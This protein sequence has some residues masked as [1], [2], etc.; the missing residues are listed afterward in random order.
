[1]RKRGWKVLACALLLALLFAGAD[2]A[3]TG[4]KEQTKGGDC[5]RIV[6]TY[7]YMNDEDM[8][9]MEE[10]VDA[11][12]EISRDEIGVEVELLPVDALDS[13]A[14]YP[15]WLGRGD[16]IDL[17]LINYQNI[18]YYVDRGMLLPLNGLLDC[19]GAGIEEL[20][21]SQQNLYSGATADGNVYGVN[22][23]SYGFASGGGLWMS[24]QLLEEASF[25][26]E[27]EH[28]YS[29]E[30]LDVL[31]A[32]LKER[33]PDCYP[34]GQITADMTF[35]SFAYYNGTSEALGGG[36]M[37]GVMGEDGALCDLYES[38]EYYEFL[39]CMRSWY[40]KGYIYPESAYTDVRMA[41]LLQEGIILS[42]P[43]SSQPGVVSKE[44]IPD[45][46]CLLTSA[47]TYG[48]GSRTGIFWTIP[49]TSREPEAA[50]EFLN[51]MYTDERIVNLF[52]LGI[53]GK[54]YV[55]TDEARGIVDYPK[56]TPQQE[57]Y[58]C[59]LGVYGNMTL[60]Y[61]FSW[62][63]FREERKE[64][65]SLARPLGTE[66]EGFYFD[67][68]EVAAQEARVQEVL[69]SYLPALESGSIPLAVNYEQFVS[70]L[71]EAGI[72][73]IIAEKQRQLDAWLAE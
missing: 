60:K 36:V 47:I 7:Q 26:Y 62:E 51:L 35:S 57:R 55:F 18:M 40:L 13:F 3:M 14:D 12:N 5:R 1:M 68:S 46:V 34:L 65:A 19:C 73:E 29:M 66:Y 2:R 45:A 48:P 23:C 25:F 17:M 49:E 31:F 54:D 69:N 70:A 72:D 6:M 8:Q 30:E 16:V 61:C 59:P 32:R 20:N 22:I 52:Q 4:E 67:E 43:L 33:Y 71:K 11:V 38:E 37:S 9:H 50:M 64:Y 24:G 56:D 53:E 27:R 15:V 39:S 41:Q 58:R 10:I 28:I 63:D 44:E 21:S 42:H